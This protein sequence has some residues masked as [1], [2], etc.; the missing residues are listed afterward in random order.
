M[1]TD[2]TQ[3]GKGFVRRFRGLTGIPLA[4]F[5][6]QKSAE[7][8]DAFAYLCFICAHLWQK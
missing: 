5:Q 8:V 6:R 4:E 2:E 3:M 7:F 1:H